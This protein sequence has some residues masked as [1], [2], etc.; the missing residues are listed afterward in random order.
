MPS[1]SRRGATEFVAVDIAQASLDE[2]ERQVG[3]VTSTPIRKVL[4]DVAEPEA[5]I[6]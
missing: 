4:I 3:S 2:C 6:D 1:G 5:A